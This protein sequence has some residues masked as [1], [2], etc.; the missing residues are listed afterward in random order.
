[1]G[2]VAV[3]VFIIASLTDFLDGYL[4]RKHKLVSDVGNFLDTIADKM[5]TVSALIMVC[6]VLA[7]N[8]TAGDRTAFALVVIIVVCSL[9]NICR[10]LFISALKMIASSKGVS[11]VADKLGKVKMTLQVFALILL[12]PVP[13]IAQLHVFTGEVIVSIGTVLLGL[14]TIMALISGIN[15]LVKYKAVFKPLPLESASIA[16]EDNEEANDKND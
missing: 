6:V 14:A 10:D 15:Y 5:L 3:G 1:M 9:I 2:F 16:V 7:L 11:V 8:V 13:N 4:A 12:I